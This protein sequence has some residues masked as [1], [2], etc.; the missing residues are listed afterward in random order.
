M[1]YRG[2][3]RIPHWSVPEVACS[4]AFAFTIESYT[5]PIGMA[6]C[7]PSSQQRVFFGQAYEQMAV[8]INVLTLKSMDS[9]G[10]NN[11]LGCDE[12]LS[13]SASEGSDL[14]CD[15]VLSPSASEG[16]DL[17]CDEVLSPS[18]SEGREQ[19][20]ASARTPRNLFCFDEAPKSDPEMV[21]DI[22]HNDM[23]REKQFRP[24][25]SLLQET[26]PEIS[27]SDREFAVRMLSEASRTHGLGGNTV[28]LA[29]SYLDRLL[30][31]HSV[32]KQSLRG[33]SL[34]CL[35]LACNHEEVAPY[36]FDYLLGQDQPVSPAQQMFCQNWLFRKLEFQGQVPTAFSFLHLFLQG[37]QGMSHESPEQIKFAYDLVNLILLCYFAV[38]YTPSAIA[39]A[40]LELAAEA[41][42]AESPV[43]K[44]KQLAPGL[45]REAALKLRP[46]A[47]D[48]PRSLLAAPTPQAHTS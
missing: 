37:M 31:V 40:A 39:A 6:P 35:S 47:H 17:G 9:D 19:R 4:S 2:Q 11:A 33:L 22:I 42:N 15:E 7:H 3:F 25:S 41:H 36:D 48:L 32:E 27:P 34:T 23:Q 14:G 30:S 8:D 28:E 45:D 18:A 20:S 43:D 1:K 29:V 16:S 10:R 26:S 24:K 38:D 46:S 13:S 12:V 44:L 5:Q 21:P